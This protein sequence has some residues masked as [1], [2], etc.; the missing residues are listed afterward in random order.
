MYRIAL[1]QNQSE[2]F[3]LSYG[4]VYSWFAETFD[5]Y[6]WNLY[7][8]EK[9]LASLFD[10]MDGEYYDAVIFT[11]NTF[12][13]IYLRAG[14]GDQSARTQRFLR[15]NKG[16]LV[17]QQIKVAGETLEMLPDHLALRIVPRPASEGEQLS[18]A[19]LGV[20]SDH[21]LLHYPNA[22][23]TE[24]IVKASLQNPAI[25]YLYWS[26]LTP[27]CPEYWIEILCDDSYPDG[28]RPLML[29][30]GPQTPGRVVV[31]SLVL[32][33]Q[34]QLTPL[35][36]LLTYV[37][38]GPHSMA[39]V[40]RSGRSSYDF[41]YLLHNLRIAKHAFR[42]Y[43]MDRLDFRALQPRMHDVVVLDP[44]WPPA[45]ITKD[46]LETF[47]A[48]T[49]RHTRLIYFDVESFGEPA[50]TTVG[51][52]LRFE[53]RYQPAITYLKDAFDRDSGRWDG[54]YFRTL[55]VLDTLLRLGEPIDEYQ[56]PFL[57]YIRPHDSE[58]SYDRQFATTC[59]LLRVY[60]LFLGQDE[61]RF[62]RTLDWLEREINT[63]R[64]TESDLA[65]AYLAFKQCGVPVPLDTVKDLHRRLSPEAA[66]SEEDAFRYISLFL[67]YGLSQELMPI[68]SRLIQLQR[69]DG[70]WGY[71]EKNRLFLTA[72]IVDL[73][74]SVKDAIASEGETLPGLDK[75][76]LMAVIHLKSLDLM[77]LP[78]KDKAS[79]TAAVLQAIRHFESEIRFPIDEFLEEQG[80]V[81]NA[82]SLISKLQADK[83]KLAQE[84][85]TA[86]CQL[87][88]SRQTANRIAY[89]ILVCVPLLIVSLSLNVSLAIRYGVGEVIQPVLS[90]QPSWIA[91]FF[92][93]V[94]VMFALMARRRIIPEKLAEAIRTTHTILT[95][96]ASAFEH[97]EDQEE[98]PAG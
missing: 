73:L 35:R 76:I 83:V 15:N 16:I 91:T 45:A 61:P 53:I 62:K 85:R 82:N 87:I 10:R 5:E 38:E 68:A 41:E 77:S 7:S 3:E 94:V 93:L 31:T 96:P 33:W 65:R 78:P 20:V 59:A 36:N 47:R 1:L 95:S 13:D 39:V 60:Y 98:T 48:C 4:D 26:Y 92:A 28:R 69:K 22:I 19:K 8:T 27:L 50:L 63:H 54:S 57:E 51:G 34:R 30:S 89:T 21:M 97:D 18:D 71:E 81:A 29:V 17:F 79:T 70:S 52:I 72:L 88:D 12:N 46:Q 80:I 32:D 58:G 6:E 40:R 67:S 43:S 42:E 14:W 9:S 49:K 24:E 64:K 25:E 90:V 86:V 75:S 44:A 23:Q 11:T 56:E 66:D 74:L 55:H 84:L 37:T 2:A